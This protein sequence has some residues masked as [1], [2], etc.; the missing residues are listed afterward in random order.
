MSKITFSDG[1]TFDTGGKMRITRR[2]DGYYVV[3][4]GMLL[5]VDSRKEGEKLIK[6]FTEKR[7]PKKRRNYA[8]SVPKHIKPT[9]RK[10]AEGIYVYPRK[11]SF[12]IGDLFHARLALIYA[13]SSMHHGQRQKVVEA[14]AQHYPQYN[15][16]AWWNAQRTDLLKKKRGSGLKTWSYYLAKDNPRKK[17]KKT[18]T[19]KTSR[20]TP[21]SLL[22]WKK[23]GT[24]NGSPILEKGRTTVYKDGPESIISGDSLGGEYSGPYGSLYPHMP[25]VRE[26]DTGPRFRDRTTLYYATQREA[27]IGGEPRL[28]RAAERFDQQLGDEWRQREEDAQ[29]DDFLSSPEYKATLARLAA[30]SS[31]YNPRKT[32]AGWKTIGKINGAAILHKGRTKVYKDGPELPDTW[33]YPMGGPYGDWIYPHLPWVREVVTSTSG[34]KDGLRDDFQFYATQ[35]EAKKGGEPRLTPG[36]ERAIEAYGE[37]QE[38]M[39]KETMRWRAK[40]DLYEARHGVNNPRRRRN[41]HAPLGPW[42]ALTRQANIRNP[43]AAHGWKRVGK[44]VVKKGAVEVR[45]LKG[46]YGRYVRGQMLHKYPT[47]TQAKIG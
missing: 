17:K 22:G 13:L 39:K 37:E 19:R 5:P 35:A 31:S 1:M 18:T 7:M 42:G 43:S 2:S 26:V 3:G 16:G 27:K 30:K 38:E 4:G 12:P 32:T 14:V 10:A 33:A 41:A 36:A 9:S 23:T 34:S 40:R 15:W 29:A 45:K 47:Q 21:K 28:T 11:K 44:G 20:K 6:Q 46:G 8:K 25:W 24:L